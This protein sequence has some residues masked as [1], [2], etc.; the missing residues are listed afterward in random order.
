MLG[1]SEQFVPV[2]GKTAT[3]ITTSP[4]AVHIPDRVRYVQVVTTA[5][6]YVGL[7]QAYTAPAVATV[8]G[9]TTISSAGTPTGGTFTITL[10]PGTDRAFTT[11]ALT[12]NESAADIKT[13]LILGSTVAVTGDITAAGGALPTA[14]TLTWTGVYAGTVPPLIVNSAVTGGTNSRIIA[15]TT[16][17][18]AQNGGYAYVEASTPTVLTRSR[19]RF[20][21][22]SRYLY[23][24]SVSSTV[25][26]FLT[27]YA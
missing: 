22:E 12:Y 1:V 14:V 4:V 17:A 23:I 3:G 20:G 26:Y 6:A 2:G 27:Y 19:D 25:D 8:N 15:R 13:A 24:A 7:G 10:F 9:I 16:T 11:S 5:R 21:N 18:P